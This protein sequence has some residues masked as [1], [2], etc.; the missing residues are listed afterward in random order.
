MSWSITPT[1]LTEPN[2][3][4]NGEDAEAEDCAVIGY[5]PDFSQRVW[6]DAPCNSLY[7]YALCESLPTG[8][9]C[10]NNTSTFIYSTGI[11]IGVIVLLLISFSVKFCIRRGQGQENLEVKEGDGNNVDTYDTYYDKKNSVG[12]NQ[13]SPVTYDTY[14]TYTY[15]N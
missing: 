4:R 12:M 7:A 3:G 5:G 10:T 15:Y 14:D 11:L 13:S 1:G 8:V 9:E 2:D 6:N